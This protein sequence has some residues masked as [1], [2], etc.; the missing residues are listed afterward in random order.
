MDGVVYPSWSPSTLVALPS[1]DI[2]I[3]ETMGYGGT[4][5]RNLAPTARQGN[6]DTFLGELREGLPGIPGSALA[7]SAD[8]VSTLRHSSSEYL[9]WQ[10]GIRPMI[11]DLKNIARS[12]LRARDIL[13]QLRHDS[14]K[15]VRRRMTFPLIQTVDQSLGS[16]GFLPSP[17]SW[18]Y[19]STKPGT[20]VSTTEKK[21]WFSGAFT[22]VWPSGDRLWDRIKLYEAEARVI[23]G[24]SPDVSTLWELSKFSWLFDWFADLGDVLSGISITNHDQLVAPHAYIM[25]HYS[26]SVDLFSG[27][28][29]KGQPFF[30]GRRL[31][32]RK[33]RIRAYPYGFDVPT[34]GLS[35]FQTSIL[36]ALGINRGPTTR[37]IKRLK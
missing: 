13:G 35:A 8:T 21:Y 5:W 19:S 24:L 6:L 26:S 11:S 10:F 7:R 37:I 15:I 30:Q 12:V 28:A 9:N 20:Y 29:L 2:Q 3:T 14:G 18:Y 34:E 22:Y 36:V 25:S 31:L 23:L 17:A 33:M 1:T 27:F 32:E 16:I 4:A